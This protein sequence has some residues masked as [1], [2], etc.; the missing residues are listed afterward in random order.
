MPEFAFARSPGPKPPLTIG[1]VGSIGRACFSDLLLGALP[2]FETAYRCGAQKA[3]LAALGSQ[4]LDLAVYPGARAPAFQTV[5]LCHDHLVVAMRA[6]HALAALP[7]VLAESLR[8]Q[9]VVLPTEGEE[10]DFRRLAQALVPGLGQVAEQPMRDVTQGVVHTDA[11]ALVAAGQRDELGAAVVTRPITGADTAFPVRLA[12][13]EHNP[14]PAL[15]EL[16]RAVAGL[17]GIL[18]PPASD[19]GICAAREEEHGAELDG[20]EGRVIG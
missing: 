8:G 20:D 19:G 7:S 17:H 2:D 13:C 5:V 1:F 12:W 15:R 14:S 18:S 10:G 6:S 16:L 4:Q 3:L 11:I 9:I